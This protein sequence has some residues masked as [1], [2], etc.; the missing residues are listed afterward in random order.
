MDLVQCADRELE[1]MSLI[2]GKQREALVR[3]EIGRISISRH[4]A[5]WSPQSDRNSIRIGIGLF[6]SKRA[7]DWFDL[8]HKWEP[9][10]AER[11][12][13][14]SNQNSVEFFGDTT[15]PGGL[16]RVLIGWGK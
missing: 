4:T 10:T 3:I 9:M 8:G 6:A 2:L 5:A 15:Y 14:R 16:E 7:T 1:C 11:E 12:S 13:S